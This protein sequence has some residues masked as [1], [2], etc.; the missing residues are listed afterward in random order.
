MSTPDE[1]RAFTRRLFDDPE[2][3]PAESDPE[4]GNHS[5]READTPPPEKPPT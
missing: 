5:P 2:Q 3:T 1:L 4:T